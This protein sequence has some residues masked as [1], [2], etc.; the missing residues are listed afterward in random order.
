[1]G[2]FAP[3]VVGLPMALIAAAVQD[4]FIVSAEKLHDEPL[5]SVGGQV[6]FPYYGKNGGLTSKVIAYRKEN[7]SAVPYYVEPVSP[8][9]HSYRFVRAT[10]LDSFKLN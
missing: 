10:N 7:G 5:Y 3:V 9:R 1:M 2:A 6:L 8:T 4:S